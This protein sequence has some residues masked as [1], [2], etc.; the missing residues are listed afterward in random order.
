MLYL[1]VFKIQ[2]NLCKMLPLQSKVTFVVSFGENNKFIYEEMKR[3]GI[4][5]D[6][7]FLCKG[8]CK[9]DFE[10]RG[11]HVIDFETL[12]LLDMWRGI[13]HLAT[14]RTVF[15]DNYYGFLSVT[16]FKED[17]QCIQIWH[18]AGAIKKFGLEDAAASGRSKKAQERFLRVYKKFDKIVV[19]SDAL[20]NVF[21]KAF[22][23][24][25]GNVVKTGIPRT[26]LFFDKNAARE[27]AAGLAINSKIM[28]EKKVIL[29]APTFRDTEL[30][31][32]NLKLDLDLMQ[33]EL[34]EDYVLF[35]K[36]HPAVKTKLNYEQE[37]PGFVYDYSDY[38][39]IN[40][41]L[42]ITDILITD[43][44]SIPYEFALLNRPMIFFPYDLEDYKK[45]RGL[46][47]DY[48]SLVPGPVVYTTGD[49]VDKIKKQA[50]DLSQIEA[51]SGKW[52]QYSKGHSSEN[53]VGLLFKDH[54]SIEEQ[55]SRAL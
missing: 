10:A 35:L 22:N 31:A 25:A 39:N 37:F 16:D 53:L 36:V 45:E 6:V 4:T 42:L 47:D 32:F 50:F 44:S 46:W 27:I 11:S 43:Y 9:K 49:I 12:N 41:L 3:Q 51:F 8:S 24:S 14:S 28:K 7:V 18:A 23:I 40:E 52:N 38:G 20:A 33:K 34:G 15:V 26:D 55:Q 2:F 30:S 5:D 48:E 54:I 13:Y 17:V 29:Y 21:M 1:F 19:G